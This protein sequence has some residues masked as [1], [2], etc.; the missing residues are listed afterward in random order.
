MKGV[1]IRISAAALVASGFA[2]TAA[3]QFGGDP[4]NQV[5]YPG[6][7]A[8]PDAGT[9]PAPDAADQDQDNVV[10]MDDMN[11]QLAPDDADTYIDDEAPPQDGDTYPGKPDAD[12]DA[13]FVD[14]PKAVAA[15]T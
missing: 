4:Q 12:D 11:D 1:V 5:D 2:A 15:A 14:K 3:A 6:N 10:Y 7:I 9:R 8:A 13:G